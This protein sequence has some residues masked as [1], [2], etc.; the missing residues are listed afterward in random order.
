MKSIHGRPCLPGGSVGKESTCNAGDPGSI[1]GWGRSPGEGNSNPLQYSCLKKPID[2][3][4]LQGY[5]PWGHKESD[6]TQWLN[7]HH[8]HSRPAA[9]IILDGEKLKG[10]SLRSRT[11]Q[12]C[13]LITFIQHSFG[14]P[15][16]GS[17]RRKRNGI[18]IGKEKVKLTVCR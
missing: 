6:M 16:H 15:G 2:R 17:Q 9:N 5:S 13:Q 12:Q 14:S 10:F 4:S 3:R 18:K 8:H 11:R 7:H 1:P